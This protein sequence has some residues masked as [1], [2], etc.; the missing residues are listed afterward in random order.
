MQKIP[1][2]FH[3]SSRMEDNVVLISAAVAESGAA[4]WAASAFLSSM[5]LIR[6]SCIG[7]DS[8][9]VDIELPFFELPL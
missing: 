3:V 9:T 1:I 4:A 6:I 8:H 5:Q 7:G 2:V